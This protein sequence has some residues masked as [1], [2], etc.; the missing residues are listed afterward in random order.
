MRTEASTM[1]R[2]ASCQCGQ[3]SITVSGEPWLVSACNCTECQRRS[4]SAF[5]YSARWDTANVVA[6]T[7]EH[8]TYER[9]GDSGRSVRLE[10]CPTCGSTVFSRA[11]MYPDK[12]SVAVGC[13][14]EPNFG[15][16]AIAVWCRSKHG[17]VAFPATTRPAETGQIAIGDSAPV[18]AGPSDGRRQRADDR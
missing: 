17:W 9:R 13:F 12:L 2:T 14:A 3:L 15:P 18:S 16:P 6:I 1:Q 7:G 8:T 5:S 10:F 11:E 4:G